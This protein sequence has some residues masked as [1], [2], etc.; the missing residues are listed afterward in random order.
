MVGMTARV[1]ARSL[2]PGGLAWKLGWPPWLTIFAVL[3]EGRV[4]DG[5]KDPRIADFDAGFWQLQR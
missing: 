5:S 4:A 1:L 2:T 3:P